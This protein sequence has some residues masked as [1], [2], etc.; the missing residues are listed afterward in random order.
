[1]GFEGYKY[2][3]ELRAGHSNVINDTKHRHFHTFVITLYMRDMDSNVNLYEEVE[4]RINARLDGYRNRY[5]DETPLF[6]GVPT[7]LE[8]MGDRFFDELKSEAGEVGFEVIKLEI[9]ESPVRT[10]SVSDRMLDSQANE[11]SRLPFSFIPRT[12]HQQQEASATEAAAARESEPSAEA[13][14]ADIQ[15]VAVA[16]EV[17]QSPFKINMLWLLA[18]FML[19]CVSM[20]VTLLI[21]DSGLYPRGSD[22]FCHIYRA[23]LLL[24]NIKAGNFYPLY[25]SMWYNGVEIMRYWGPLPLYLLAFLQWLCNDMLG[26]YTM[27]AGVMCLIGGMGWLMWGRK[28]NR[29]GLAAFMAVIWF[30]LPQNIM[31]LVQAGNLPRG[32]LHNLL[33]YLLYFLWGYLHEHKRRQWLGIALMFSL[34]GLCHIG[35]TIMVAVIV[36]IYT[37]LSVKLDK[38]KG[39]WSVAAAIAG[40]ILLIGIWVVPSLVGGMVGSGSTS[41]QVMETFFQSLFVSFNPMNRIN[42]ELTSYYF[43]LSVAVICIIGIAVGKKKV[44]AG[45]LTVLLIFICTGNS[46]Y[47]LLSQLPFSKYLWM[48]RMIPVVLA[49]FTMSFLMWDKLKRWFV[50]AMCVLL[51]LDCI[52][53]YQ[54]IVAANGQ[55]VE[56]AMETIRDRGSELMLETAKNYTK[57]RLAVYDLSRYEAFAPFYVSGVDNNTRYMF[58]AG[59]EGAATAKNIVML[60]TAVENE[61]FV[62]VFDRSIEMGCDTILFADCAFD[63]G[64][65]SVVEDIDAAAQKTGFVRR[66]LGSTGAV[67]TREVPGT[68]GTITSYDN[69]AIGSAANDMAM[70]FP[71]FEEGDSD[72]LDDYTVEELSKY[73]I[74]YLSNVKYLSTEEAE[75]KL[76][77]VAAKGTHVIIDMN[78]IPADSRTNN[79]AI[80][81]VTAQTI[82]FKDEYPNMTY[83]GQNYRTQLFVDEYREWSTVYLEGLKEVTGYGMLNGKKLPF[84]GNAGIDNITFLGYNL[85]YHSLTAKDET[86]IELLEKIFGEDSEKL[87]DRQIVPVDISCESGKIIIN[88]KQDN[89]NV[90]LAALDIFESGQEV[91]R[92]HNLLFVNSGETVINIHYPHFVKGLLLSL[93]GLI[94][95]IAFYVTRGKE[96]GYEKRD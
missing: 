70:I 1:M 55:K 41:N 90:A 36:L 6:E 91:A 11:I 20:T 2:K 15:P 93:V 17:K 86:G 42:G 89:V 43:G 3:F 80:F 16:T 28:Y 45:F 9:C 88:T 75:E 18:C 7:T 66:E 46:A 54:Y 83:G 58:G 32:L 37:A 61:S 35:T 68:F 19:V 63:E 85:P 53:S 21:T 24:Q 5:L 50:A 82:R 22:T 47:A 51:L 60:N 31:V 13:D 57:Q 56:D 64:I 95:I 74:V 29:I 14:V 94:A 84:A 12:V 81:G 69:L 4:A 59:W 87:P 96:Y 73:K 77:Q 23:D 38:N 39:F 52:P 76:T 67:Y 49:V 65:A 26:G 8:S 62:Y 30:F 33:P 79:Q 92:K 48:I 71:T 72:N 10:Y 25:D 34:M 44:R 40:G 27:Y 78:R